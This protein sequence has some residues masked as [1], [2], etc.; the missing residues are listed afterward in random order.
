METLKCF[1]RTYDHISG[2]V[3]EHGMMVEYER[4]EMMLHV[5]PKRLWRKAITKVGLNP[6]ESR[7]FEYSKLKG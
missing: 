2:V 1:L 5:L 4:M 7:I 6:L 3:T